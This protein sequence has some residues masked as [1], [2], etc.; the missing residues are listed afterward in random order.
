MPILDFL[1]HFRRKLLTFYP[2][3]V[4]FGLN[5][6]YDVRVG[7]SFYV[8]HNHLVQTTEQFYFK[9]LRQTFL[10]CLRLLLALV[11]SSAQLICLNYL[12]EQVAQ[13]VQT[14]LFQ[15]N[16][17]SVH[18]FALIFIV[19]A[20]LRVFRD[21]QTYLSQLYLTS[22]IIQ[23]NICTVVCCQVF[24]FQITYH[25]SLSPLQDRRV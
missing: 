11:S 22:L 3:S 4:H 6:G 23:I 2:F 12:Y 8:S 21:H 14:Y 17:F 10:H 15:L 16:T 1:T 13:V 7:A 24:E 18:R 20:K 19:N 5:W 9:V 25:S